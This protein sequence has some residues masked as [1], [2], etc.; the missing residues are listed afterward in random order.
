MTATR[1][2][3]LQ[4][5][6]ALSLA[7]HAAVLGWAFGGMPSPG[8]RGD[9]SDAKVV[10]LQMVTP[11]PPAQ[12]Q[13]TEASPPPA[14]D[15]AAQQV[16]EPSLA[17]STDVPLPRPA[18]ASAEPPSA[19]QGDGHDDYLPRSMLTVP[20]ELKS[21]VVLD[22]PDR[23]G[24]RDGHYSGVIV[25]YIDDAGM[26]RRVE[27]EGDGLP[28]PLFETARQ[29]FTG[30]LFEPGQLDGHVVKSRIRIQV[31]FDSRPSATSGRL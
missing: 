9:G 17:T 19:A 11:R 20:P 22:W 28:A 29:A 15:V 6:A 10:H 31:Q 18:S 3:G 8:M 5:C 14:V 2:T 7:G 4:W 27:P 26:V 21:V 1:W 23:A 24:L 25:L 30:A 12:V 16:P 13:A